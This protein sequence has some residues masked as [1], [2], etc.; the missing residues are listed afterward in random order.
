MPTSTAPPAGHRRFDNLQRGLL[1][2]DRVEG[3]IDAEAFGHLRTGSKTF[4]AVALIMCVAPKFFVNSRL[5]SRR[6]QAMDR[7]GP[8]EPRDLHDIEADATAPDYQHA[9]AGR[10]ARMTDHRADAGRDAAANDRRMGERQ[11][12]ADFDD[13]L[14]RT[15][16]FLRERSDAGHLVDWLAVQ[17]DARRPVMHA[18]TR[19]IIV[20]DAKNGLA[21]RAIAATAAMRAEGKD[22]VVAGFDIVDLQPF[23]KDD[24]S[25]LVA[26]HYRRRPV[27]VHDVPI[28]HA[29]ASC[30][31][32][33]TDPPWL[34]AAPARDQRS[35]RV[36]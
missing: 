10:D 31:G 35:A 23:L 8:A 18:P 22:D 27:A 4:S 15:D 34:S 7:A 14:G 12:V 11:V 33:N 5:L 9:G 6:S 29:D 28:A 19:R 21:G 24:P 32:A 17:P 1:A 13:L 30:L 20:P 3:V 36:C 16:H 25:S 2:A 26:E